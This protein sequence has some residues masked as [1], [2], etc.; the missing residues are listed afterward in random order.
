M[1]IKLETYLKTQLRFD[2]GR[3]MN[4]FKDITWGL[5]FVFYNKIDSNKTKADEDLKSIEVNIVL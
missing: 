4:I 3:T 1:R 5:I 2:E